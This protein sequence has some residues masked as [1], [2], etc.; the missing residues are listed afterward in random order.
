MLKLR[1]FII[2]IVIYLLAF[3][4]IKFELNLFYPYDMLKNYLMMPVIVSASN[5]NELQNSNE[6]N[7]IV[8]NNLKEEINELKELSNIKTILSGYENINATVIERNRN[9]WFNTIKIDKGKDDGISL[10]MAVVDKYGLIGKIS[11][12]SKNMSEIKL[13]TTTDLNNKTSVVIINGNEKIYGIINGYNNGYLEVILT[14]SNLDVKEDLNV[15]TTGMGGIYPS[16]IL[17]GKTKG[18]K[19][20]KYGVGLIVLVRPIS[21]FNNLKYVSALR[22]E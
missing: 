2:L 15:L 5:E 1:T 7:E 22:R 9:Y 13:I 4:S 19:S 10:N 11:H 12:V 21:D 14:T 17:I 3:L 16:G 20:A 18:I 6:Y 8:I